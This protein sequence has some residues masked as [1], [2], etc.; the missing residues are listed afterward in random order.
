MAHAARKYLKNWAEPEAAFAHAVDETYARALVVPAF[1]ESAALL[2]GYVRAAETSTGTTLCILVVNAP[3]DATEAEHR[4]TGLCLDGVIA[5]LAGE[6]ELSPSPRRAVLGTAR[7]GKLDVLVIDRAS[8]GARIPRKEGVGLA[9]KVGFDVALALH[10][11]GKLRSRFVYGTDADATLPDGHAS[12]PRSIFLDA[13]AVLFPFWHAAGSIPPSH[14][15][16][17][18]TS[19]RFATT[20]PGSPS[21]GR[22]TRS[23]PSGAR[24]R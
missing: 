17:R 1:C 6:R 11:A 22:R 21:R 15:P 19:C 16:R 2:S 23:I 9:R 24:W 5:S 4:E 7:A 12:K 3:E 8:V 20:L 18:T 14:S 10:A 13:A